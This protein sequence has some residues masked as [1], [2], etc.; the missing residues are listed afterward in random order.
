MCKNDL[1]FMHPV[2]SC[3]G[4]RLRDLGTLIRTAISRRV[5]REN[6]N[7]KVEFGVVRDDRL[8]PSAAC[9]MRK[10]ERGAALGEK[11]LCC[12]CSRSLARLASWRLSAEFM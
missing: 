4:Q 11:L 6:R 1:T 9:L 10:A 12:S 8:E 3:S 5:Y 7:G 2:P